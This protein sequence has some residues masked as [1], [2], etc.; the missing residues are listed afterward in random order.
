[1]KRKDLKKEFRM[2][3]RSVSELMAEMG[4]FSAAD[5]KF[6]MTLVVSYQW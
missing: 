1:M 5:D 6:R 2:H 3:S 4:N